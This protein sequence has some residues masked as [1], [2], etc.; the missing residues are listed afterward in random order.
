MLHSQ[1][2][3]TGDCMGTA[4]VSRSQITKFGPDSGYGGKSRLGYL[5]SAQVKDY[6]A[7]TGDHIE[8]SSLDLGIPGALSVYLDSKHIR[9][10]LKHSLAQQSTE[11]PPV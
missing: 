7:S 2:W 11:G 3:P 10:C 5:D 4:N 1:V 8:I 9:A 6:K